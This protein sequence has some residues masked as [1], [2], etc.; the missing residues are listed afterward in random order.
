MAELR[1]TVRIF[2]AEDNPA[3]AFLLKE[4]LESHGIEHEIDRCVDGEDCVGRL[5]KEAATLQPDLIIVDL[6]LPR[7][8]GLE[9]LKTVRAKSEFDGVPVMVLTSSQSPRDRQNAYDFGA[10]AFV[11]KPP[12][13]DDFLEIVGRSVSSMLQGSR[14]NPGALC[15]GHNAKQTLVGGSKAPRG[16][17][18]FARIAQSSSY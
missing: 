2:L 12:R 10:D 13:L 7:V 16:G 4:A 6:N 1:R 5:T 15:R 14:R 8:D 9:V 3:D 18:T 11:S 17:R